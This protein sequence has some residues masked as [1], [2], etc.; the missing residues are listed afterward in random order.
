MKKLVFVILT[1][2]TLLSACGPSTTTLSPA[3]LAA[4]PDDAHVATSCLP[5]YASMPSIVQPHGTLVVD[6]YH[7]TGHLF[8]ANLTTGKQAALWTANETIAEPGVSPD[9]KALAFKS[10]DPKTNVWSVVIADAQ[11]NRVK[12]TPWP[13][14]Y[15]ILGNWINNQ[16]LL[17]STNPPLT[18]FNPYDNSRQGYQFSDLP[19]FSEDPTANRV[20]LF[21][22]AVDRVVYKDNG[23]KV[24]LLDLAAK[25]ALGTVPNQTAPFPIAAW[26]PD[27]KQVAV[28][29]KTLL[30]AKPSDQGDD[31][32]GISR[33]GQVTQLTHL[34]DHYGRLLTVNPAGLSW[35]PDSR[36]FAF[37]LIYPNYGANWQL[38]VHDTVTQKTTA[39]CILNRD[40][41]QLGYVHPLPVPIWS[42][43]SSQIMVE[44]RYDTSSNHIL[45][46][47]L[48]Q[49]LAFP[50]FDNM[51]PAGWLASNP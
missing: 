20:A 28:V 49:K 34:T 47:D 32:F 18:I 38:A 30:G 25:K 3:D 14:G 6:D 12:S 35:S 5:V 23:G 51:Y 45:I 22:P 41:S 1:L 16:Q 9:R 7:A 27:G 39:Y 42:P 29:G 24:T 44:N 19:N 37:W 43:D 4:P 46:V 17:L 40:G 26:S 33:D 31:I 15:F 36:F 2:A 21:N 10:G 50:V 13:Q 8:L 11:G 48:A